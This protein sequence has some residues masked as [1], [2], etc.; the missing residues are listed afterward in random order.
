MFQ[1]K[2]RIR[3]DRSC[4]DADF[5]AYIHVLSTS[6][7]VGLLNGERRLGDLRQVE[8]LLMLP[9]ETQYS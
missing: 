7:A 3:R 9:R 4:L 6:F 1:M 5:A 2:F 8:E